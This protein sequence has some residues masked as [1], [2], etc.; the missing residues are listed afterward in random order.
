MAKL[1]IVNADDFGKTASV[2]RAVIR[3]FETGLISSTTLMTNM[4]G[5]AEA[6]TLTTQ[7]ELHGKVGI[8]LNLIEGQPLTEAMCACRRFCNPHGRFLR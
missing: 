4:P 1:L 6:C 2:N 7:H 5:F 3:A 8:H